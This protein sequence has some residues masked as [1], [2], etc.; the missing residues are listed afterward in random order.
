MTN[1]LDILQFR[2]RGLHIRHRHDS[3]S[4]TMGIFF[5]NVDDITAFLVPG[6]SG[7]IPAQSCRLRNHPRVVTFGR[8]DLVIVS[9]KVTV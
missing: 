1:A 9:L 8:F 7:H 6:I 5:L 2:E 3:R 4:F